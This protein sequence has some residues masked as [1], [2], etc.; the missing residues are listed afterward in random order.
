MLF[1]IIALAT[2]TMLANPDNPT[3]GNKKSK[4]TPEQMQKARIN[5]LIND[6]GLDDATA[7]KFTSVYKEYDAEMTNI[8]KSYA[9]NNKKWDDMTDA[10]IDAQTKARF[11][12]SRKILDVR[13]KYYDRFRTFLTARQVRKIYSMEQK[14]A[15]K[16]KDR[17]GKGSRFNSIPKGWYK[18]HK[19][20]NAN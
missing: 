16:V 17:K 12:Q 2:S 6:L 11:Q 19:S 13:E 1:A 14:M 4:P 18:G 10:E 9:K 20:P 8:R 5:H 3:S 15:K 7:A